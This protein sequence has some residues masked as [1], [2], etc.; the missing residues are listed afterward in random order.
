MILLDEHGEPFSGR[1]PS[2]AKILPVAVTSLPINTFHQKL[3]APGVQRV[4]DQEEKLKRIQENHAH[5]TTQT[6]HALPTFSV[7]PLPVATAQ[8]P[9]LN[10]LRQLQAAQLAV[11]SLGRKKR[12]SG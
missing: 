9:G 4:L 7:E 12:E 2:N 10:Q 11:L 3:Q 5:S 6:S 8:V 1:L